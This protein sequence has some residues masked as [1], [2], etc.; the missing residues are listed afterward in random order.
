MSKNLRDIYTGVVKNDPNRNENDLYPTPPL[1]TYILCKYSDVPKNVIEPCAGQGNIS[2]ELKRNGINVRS[3]DLFQY[4]QNFVDDIETGKDFLTLPKQE[5]YTG[6][7]TNPPYFKNLPAKILKKSLEE[8][9]YTALFLRLTF[10]E[11]IRRY[12]LFKKNP[13]S[14]IIFLS[15]R[16][17]FK[18]NQ[19]GEPVL[20]TDQIGGMISYMWIIFD[21]RVHA[22]Q[23][24]LKWAL[25]RDEYGEWYENY[26][27]NKL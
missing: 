19:I 17:Q 12:E 20:A 15:D 9:D 25:L 24:D 7:V 1:A 4:E 16:V 26:K 8:Y 2:I 13:P 11:G 21:K 5:G 18:N 3:F 23:T 27:R 22:K 10:L 14:E 6:L